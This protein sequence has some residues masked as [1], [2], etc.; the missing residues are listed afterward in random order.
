[1]KHIKICLL[2]LAVGLAGKS[3]SQDLLTTISNI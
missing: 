3:W 1:M 2:L